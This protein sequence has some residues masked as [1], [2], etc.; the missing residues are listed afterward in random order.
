MVLI[1]EMLI[2]TVMEIPISD[3]DYLMDMVITPSRI[4]DHIQNKA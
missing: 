3:H 1:W 4:Y 2:K